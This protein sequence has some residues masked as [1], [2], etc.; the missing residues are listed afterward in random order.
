MNNFITP[1]EIFELYNEGLS[2]SMLADK[3]AKIENLSKADAK[4]MV[5]T[6]ICKKCL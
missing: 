2:I 1:T 5:E 3:V 6:S 4:K